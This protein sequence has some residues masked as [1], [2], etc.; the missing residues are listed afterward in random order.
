MFYHTLSVNKIVINRMGAANI[1]AMLAIDNKNIE[2]I[3][4][5]KQ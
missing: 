4:N 2:I 3:N 5:Y 1:R